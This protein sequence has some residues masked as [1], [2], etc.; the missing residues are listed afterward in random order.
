[1]RYVT[2][3]QG[4]SQKAGILSAD[5]QSVY[6][7]VEAGL[8]CKT[9]L[10]FIQNH[11]EEDI[12]H[13]KQMDKRSGT[14]IEDVR[15]LAPIPHPH[16]D[17]ICLG[18]NYMDHVMESKSV[19]HSKGD[20]KRDEAVYFSKRVVEAVGPEGKIESHSDMMHS[21]DYEAE[22]AAVL[23]K[24]AKKVAREDA[25]KYV[26]GLMCF[27]DVSAREIQH[28][29]N[30]WYFGKSLDTFTVFGPFIASLDEFT[31]P[32]EL[33]VKSR[34]NGEE[35]QHGNTRD[36]IF[37]LDYVIEELSHGITLDAGTIIATGTPA[38]VGAGFDPPRFM[39]AGDVCEI[40]IDGCG[41]LRNT[42]V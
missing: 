1:M 32:L 37:P 36:M 35:R 23:G 5:M 27:N 26:F 4:Q 29:H 10:E 13:L 42:V 39:N 20:V 41:V 3:M 24:T 34:V 9:L 7:F 21:L 16:R 33:D 11:S 19:D 18:L 8:S 28:G 17:V 15:L 40:E 38:G 30:Q 12:E 31:F 2:Y 6:S 22:L 25:W 14:P